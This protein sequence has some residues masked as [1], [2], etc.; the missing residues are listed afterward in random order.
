M[1]KIDNIFFVCP[2][3][4]PITTYS[5]HV[6][7]GSGWMSEHSEMSVCVTADIGQLGRLLHVMRPWS[8]PFRRAA[9]NM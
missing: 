7:T 1:T 4:L 5:E 3:M 2:Q 8:Q 6:L 9:Q